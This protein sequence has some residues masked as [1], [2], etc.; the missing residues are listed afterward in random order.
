MD[1]CLCFNR[2]LLHFDSWNFLFLCWKYFHVF[3]C[4]D[5]VTPLSQLRGHLSTCFWHLYRHTRFHV[6]MYDSWRRVNSLC[7]MEW[8]SLPRLLSSL[9]ALSGHLWL[10]SCVGTTSTSNTLP[11][12]TV[13]SPYCSW[14]LHRGL[15]ICKPAD[16]EL[17]VPAYPGVTS[18]CHAWLHYYLSACPVTGSTGCSL[19]C[20]KSL[21]TYHCPTIFSHLFIFV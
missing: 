18:S 8:P 7:C 21:P 6:C 9:P 15:E 1:I 13:C 11:L 12:P 5:D 10:S 17:Q 16:G 20:C 4:V 3:I 19:H 2:I 14:S